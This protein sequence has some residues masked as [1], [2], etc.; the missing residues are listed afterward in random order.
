MYKVGDIVT[1]KSCYDPGCNARSYRCAF[2]EDMLREFGGATLKIVAAFKNP[3]RFYYDVPDDG[4]C[5]ILE[6]T[7]RWNFT[8]GMF[9]S[10]D[11]INLKELW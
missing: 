7:E 3:N 11:P 6:G 1:V 10:K 8:S 5:Y 2:T 4:M 9:E